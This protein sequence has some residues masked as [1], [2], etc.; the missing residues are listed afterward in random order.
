MADYL[1]LVAK[2]LKKKTFSILNSEVGYYFIN[3]RWL[4]KWVSK[5]KQ[6]CGLYIK[7]EHIANT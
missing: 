4:R 3:P 7:V 6:S 1:V 2:A 5:I